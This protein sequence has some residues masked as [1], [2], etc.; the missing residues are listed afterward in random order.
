MFLT[1]HSALQQQIKASGL[2]KRELAR[3]AGVRPELLSRLNVQRGSDTRT[4]E[5]I[6]DALNFDIVLAPRKTLAQPSKAR[7]LGL[8]LPYDWSNPEIPDIALIR[9]VIEFSNLA[10]LTRLALE[11]G[12]DRLESEMRAMPLALTRS[13]ALVL[14]N[15]RAALTA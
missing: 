1:L 3:R 9:K 11:F 12:I 8:A 5:K 10:D 6:A 2:S 15:I 13:A 14:P 4:L 7:R